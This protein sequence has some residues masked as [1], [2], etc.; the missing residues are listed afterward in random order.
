MIRIVPADLRFGRMLTRACTRRVII[1]HSASP[2]VSAAE[3]HGWH[4]AK[5]WSG[6]GYHY[7]IRADGAVEAGRPLNTIGA[8]AGA[9]VNHDSIG[10]CLTGNFME[11]PP[12]DEQLQTLVRLVDGLE[13]R[14]GTMLEVLRHQDVAAT[15]CPGA[16][17]PWPEN[18]WPRERPETNDNG[19]GH[20]L[21]PWKKSLIEEA[22]AQRII[23]GPH[24]PDDPAPK[25][26]V[27][28]VGLNIMREMEKHAIKT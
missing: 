24:H 18:N 20:T 9:G 15:A 14:Y 28:A 5:G 23:T 26:F 19:P 17:F 27:L 3:I 11:Y 16:F 8:H 10:V 2:D 21:T 13:E 22:A 12:A 1:H 4:L 6:I 7:V 25:W